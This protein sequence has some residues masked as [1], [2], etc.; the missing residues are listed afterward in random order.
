MAISKPPT[1]QTQFEFTLPKGYLDSEG[2]LHREGIM[3]LATAADEIGPLRDAR[4]K[5]N[6]AYL[7][8]VILARVITRLG[9]ITELNTNIIDGLF[10]TDLTYL[11]DFYRKI[12][13]DG[14]TQISV[15]C[16]NCQHTFEVE[17]L[18]P[19]GA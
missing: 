15:T 17:G 18:E 3:R 12:N 2:N 5:S 11:Q 7:T 10:T 6:P 8:I 9:S 19:G 16:P 4:V 13:N 14:T 1:M